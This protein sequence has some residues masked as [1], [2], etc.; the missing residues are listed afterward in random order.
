MRG[1]LTALAAMAWITSASAQDAMPENGLGPYHF[2][3]SFAD[4]EATSPHTP[5]HVEAEANVGAVL[6]RGP[7]LDLG[8]AGRFTVSMLFDQDALTWIVLNGS[9]HTPCGATA[10]ALLA[11]L[12]PLFGAFSA[13]PG[14]R[15]EGRM[16]VASITPGG[17]EFRT[18]EGA[19]GLQSVFSTRRGAM[20]IQ[21]I[22]EPKAARTQGCKISII[23]S[24]RA[25]IGAAEIGL[26]EL[27]RAQ[28]LANPAWIQRPDGDRFARY[29]PEAA[30]QHGIEGHTQ[31]DCLISPDGTPRCLV[32]SEDPV[33]KGFGIAALAIARGFRVRPDN[34]VVGKRVRI[35]I[36][37]RL[38]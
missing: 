36:S 3:M 4:T 2:G 8:D 6:S 7:P 13:A 35:P 12:E 33:G 18:Y 14:P 26:D 20:Y 23:F 19:H 16:T 9:A 21:V 32:S 28:T 34:T 10:P 11:Q 38:G 1:A 31:L 17:S 29:Y 24:A 25:P 15:E 37:F 30:L 5:W 22:G 27:D